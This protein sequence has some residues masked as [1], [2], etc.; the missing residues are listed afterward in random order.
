MALGATRRDYFQKIRNISLQLGGLELVGLR[1]NQVESPAGLGEPSDELDIDLLRFVPGIDQH[2]DALK[3][4]ALQHVVGDE[5]LKK[6]APAL[7]HFGE[8]IA[9]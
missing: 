6:R 1:E 5:L 4:W 2:K 9:G 7:R 8:A 3:V